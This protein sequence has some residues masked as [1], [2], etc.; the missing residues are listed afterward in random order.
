MPHSHRWLACYFHGH[1]PWQTLRFAEANQATKLPEIPVL[2]ATRKRLGA[3]WVFRF[4]MGILRVPAWGNKKNN[5]LWAMGVS[6]KC[7]DLGLSQSKWCLS[8]SNKSGFRL[9]AMGVWRNE[10]GKEIC[11]HGLAQARICRSITLIV[12]ISKDFLN[13]NVGSAITHKVPVNYPRLGWKHNFQEMFMLF[14]V[15]KTRSPTCFKRNL[16]G[17]HC[18]NPRKIDTSFQHIFQL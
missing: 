15:T 14:W 6:R 4:K 16:Y 7:L 8:Q 2:P 18:G 1:F 10:V 5:L 12:C 3:R 11:I 17:G 9:W 13:Y